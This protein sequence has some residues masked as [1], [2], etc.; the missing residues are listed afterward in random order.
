MSDRKHKGDN[1]KLTQFHKEILRR[2]AKSINESEIKIVTDLIEREYS[3]IAKAVE[4][5]KYLNP[6]K[7]EVFGQEKM[8]VMST[9]GT[10]S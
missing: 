4:K 5:G 9:W 6:I 3:T 1:V 10:E 2:A 8:P 7:E